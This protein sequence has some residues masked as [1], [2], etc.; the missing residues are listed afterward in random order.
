MQIRMIYMSMIFKG[1]F[2]IVLLLLE[3]CELL[4]CKDTIF[5]VIYH[6]LSTYHTAWHKGQQIFAEFGVIVE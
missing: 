3:N 2:G 6:P 1:S 5:Y 4:H